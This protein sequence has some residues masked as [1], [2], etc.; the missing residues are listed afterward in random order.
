MEREW[1]LKGEIIKKVDNVIYVAFKTKMIIKK[2][3]FQETLDKAY[4]ETFGESS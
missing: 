2:P 1:K 4:N 3:S